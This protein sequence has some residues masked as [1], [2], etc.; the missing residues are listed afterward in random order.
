MQARTV[1]GVGGSFRTDGLTELASA[2]MVDVSSAEVGL[3]PPVIAQTRLM[4]P[5]ARP[6]TVDRPALVTRRLSSPARL[7][8]VSGPAG[9][10]KSTLLGQYHAVDPFPAWLSLWPEAN[11]PVVLWWS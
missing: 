10:G 11:D 3:E 1:A 4:P 6:E 9:C 8:V 5:R 7:G 2:V